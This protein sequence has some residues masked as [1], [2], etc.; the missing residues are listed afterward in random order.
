[1]IY[2]DEIPL[3]FGIPAAAVLTFVALRPAIRDFLR[4]RRH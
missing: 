4:S 2:P 3:W 1:M